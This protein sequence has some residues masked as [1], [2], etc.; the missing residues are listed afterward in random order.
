VSEQTSDH[1]QSAGGERQ[2]EPS[3]H[4]K[5]GASSG[6]AA[7]PTGDD[8]GREDQA[9]PAGRDEGSDGPVAASAGRQAEGSEGEESEESKN[10]GG[11][12]DGSKSDVISEPPPR[13]PKLDRRIH[14]FRE[15][16]ASAELK[17]LIK[18]PRFVEGTW[19]QV[20]VPSTLMH[21][22]PLSSAPVDT[23][24]LFGE[25]LMVFD[26]RDG[27][28]WTQMTRD[29]YVGYVR[30]DT[31]TQD[32]AWPT[33]F[34]RALGTFVYA[35]PDIKSQPLMHLSL[36]T[37][38]A[39]DETGETF[40]RLA[41]GGYIVT[42]HIAEEGK[43]ARDFVEIAERLIGTPYLWGGC[44]RLGIDCSGLVQMALQ[45][46]G[47]SAPRDSDMQEREL[48]S[49]VLIPDDLEG[50]QRGDLIFWPGHVGIM[51]DG[52][53]MVHANAHHMSVS[54]E[55]LPEAVERIRRGGLEITSIKRMN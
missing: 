13:R 53:M 45:A 39:V 42:R 37:P 14:A 30:A 43:F 26:V 17:G 35:K 25:V 38:L 20:A 48:G 8:D 47:R 31:L 41:T 55:T 33:H 23:E 54:V 22:H 18:A 52:I 49:T 44:S 7:E 16:L 27:W 15:D 34:V 3:A 50:L 21:R 6:R 36:N 24:A 29:R 9:G 1:D 11:S 2:K 12:D 28:A 46:T 19:S 5:A 10:G 40:S 51:V 4:G 32:I